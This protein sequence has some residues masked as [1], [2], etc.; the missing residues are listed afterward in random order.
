MDFSAIAEAGLQAGFDVEGYS[1]QAYFLM[2][3]GL[4]SM[5]AGSDPNDVDA[6]MDLVQEIKRLTLPTEMGERFKVIALSK[7]LQQPMM[8][9]SMRDQ[10]ER[11]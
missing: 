3:C 10:R 1:T 6:H 11:L 5:L 7:K 9:F 4:D 2:G 8:G